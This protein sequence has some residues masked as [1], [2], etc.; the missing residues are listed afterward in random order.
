MY[1]LFWIL[2][3]LRILPRIKQNSVLKAENGNTIRAISDLIRASDDPLL[4]MVVCDV[5]HTVYLNV[6]CSVV[7]YGEFSSADCDDTSRKS[8]L[9]WKICCRSTSNKLNESNMFHTT[10]YR[11]E[12]L[13]C[14]NGRANIRSF[15]KNMR[16]YHFCPTGE[17]ILGGRQFPI[18]IEYSFFPVGQRQTLNRLCA[19][20]NY[21]NTKTWTH[22]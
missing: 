18:L 3:C 22:C 12:V 14:S 1:C 16:D 8:T 2:D 11:K 20:S 7:S 17:P 5:Q 6:L 4:T 9:V 19:N 13:H 15:D 21:N 10:E